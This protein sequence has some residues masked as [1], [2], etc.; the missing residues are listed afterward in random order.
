MSATIGFLMM[1]Y[2]NDC[3][4]IGQDPTKF[5]TQVRILIIKKIDLYLS[6]V[7]NNFYCLFNERIY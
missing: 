4:P 2:I 3:K 6:S 1:Y 5:P 7:P